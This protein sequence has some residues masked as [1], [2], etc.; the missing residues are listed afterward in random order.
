MS[1]D[2]VREGGVSES[3][4]V[5]PSNRP[6][7]SDPRGIIGGM[8][9]KMSDGTRR[10]YKFRFYPSARLGSHLGRSFGAKRNARESGAR[11]TDP[12]V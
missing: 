6:A 2:L 11:V 9:M 3:P 1:A 7:M 4:W 5:P 8:G 12:S 10:A